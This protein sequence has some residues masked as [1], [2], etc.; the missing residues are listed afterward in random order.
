M[1]V[2][3]IGRKLIFII[4]KKQLVISLVFIVS[5]AT[6]SKLNI[7][8]WQQNFINKFSKIYEKEHHF[9]HVQRSYNGRNI[10]YSSNYDYLIN[11]I[12]LIK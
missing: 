1:H 7:L 8:H 2:C 10:Y 6:L 12:L 9:I 5:I 3:E 11:W 4:K